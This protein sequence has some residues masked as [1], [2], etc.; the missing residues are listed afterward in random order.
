MRPVKI[1]SYRMK[2]PDR[3]DMTSSHNFKSVLADDIDI[4][5]IV[6]HYTVLSNDDDR[7][8]EVI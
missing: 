2:I 8:P 4:V 5:F 7:I 6:Y 3:T 1:I